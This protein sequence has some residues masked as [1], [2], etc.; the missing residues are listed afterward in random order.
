VKVH[1]NYVGLKLFGELNC[2]QAIGGL[3]DYV[4]AGLFEE[5][6]KPASEELVIVRGDNG[7]DVMRHHAGPAP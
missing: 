6:N 1:D 5:P 7:Q 2:L 3:P 4:N